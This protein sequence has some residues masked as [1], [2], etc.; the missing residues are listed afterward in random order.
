MY[1]TVRQLQRVQGIVITQTFSL[2][3]LIG[4]QPDVFGPPFWFMLHTAAVGYYHRPTEEARHL[5]ANF[6]SSIPVVIPCSQCKEHAYNYLCK[7]LSPS[8][9]EYAASSREN[10]FKFFIDF[11]NYV[12]T[13]GKRGVMCPEVAKK[14]YGFHDEGRGA[15]VE[16][17]VWGNC[18]N[19]KGSR[20][21]G[22]I[23]DLEIFGPIFWSVLYT[24]AVN[25]FY[26]PT[27]VVKDMMTRFILAIPILVPNPLVR[28]A[29][30][31]YYLK[32]PDGFEFPNHVVSSRDTLFKFINNLE[33]HISRQFGIRHVLSLDDAKEIYGFDNGGKTRILLKYS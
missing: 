27:D 12:N 15:P 14:K 26:N 25:Y 13:K 18:E 4:S 32:H 30:R 24:A 33:Q 31:E 1:Q 23:L 8:D 3:P 29:V 7:T 11:H 19:C 20:I 16:F 6:I 2:S 21:A 9:L 22:H 28:K 17:I 5:M 10:L